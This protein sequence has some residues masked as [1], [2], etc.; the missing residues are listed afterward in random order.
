MLE[1]GGRLRLAAQQ[2]GMPAEQWLDLSTGI[3]PMGWP[4][5]D[6]P[7]EC[8]QRLPEDEDGL[9]DA[10]CRYYGCKNLLPVAGSQQAIMALPRLR[11]PGRVGMLPLAYA[12][13]AAAWKAQGHDII[14]LNEDELEKR[15]PALDVLLLINPNNPTGR[16]FSRETLLRWHW[17]LNQKGG[18]LVVDEAFA[19]TVPELSLADR[20]WQEGLVVLRSLGKFFGLAGARV[21]FVLACASLLRRLRLLIGP[22]AISNPSRFVAA[23]ALAD[24][25]WQLQTR[26]ALAQSATRLQSLLRQHELVPNGGCALF[27]WVRTARA[28]SI[29]ESLARQ[30]ILVRLFP[31]PPSLRFGLPGGEVAWARLEDTLFGLRHGTCDGA[32]AGDG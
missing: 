30:G 4:V 6:I 9:W 17:Q 8:W 15:L 32:P 27:Q 18:W 1:H 29:A 28:N 14:F 20:S 11:S 23:A 31:S 3:N 5:P 16:Y 10:A 19:D 21:G 13:H 26:I 24:N 2:Y 22:W 12:E 7:A 25:D